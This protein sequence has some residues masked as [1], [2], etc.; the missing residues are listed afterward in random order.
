MTIIAE[1]EAA[2]KLFDCLVAYHKRANKVELPEGPMSD[3]HVVIGV[4]STPELP[5]VKVS[6]PNIL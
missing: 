6:T 4:L 2:C 1:D 5:A 3:N